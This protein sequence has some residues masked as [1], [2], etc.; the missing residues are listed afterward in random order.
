[1]QQMNDTTNPPLGNDPAARDPQGTLTNNT[2]IPN[3]ETKTETKAE[4]QTLLNSDGKAPPPAP[5]WKE[6]VDD[7][8]K[9]KEENA[10]A[11]AEH[12]K[13]KPAPVKA[14]EYAPIKIEDIKLPEGYEL[15]KDAAAAALPVFHELKIDAAG[16]SKLVALYNDLAAKAQEAPYKAW[17]ELNA[18]W[19][20]DAKA[21][22]ELGP[23]F[24]QVKE[25][26]SR[27]L[28]VALTPEQRSEFSKAM[29]LTGAGNHPAFIRAF[30][31]LAEAFN[32]GKHV[33][34]KGPSEHGQ[35]NRG[36]A[37]PPTAAQA[38]YPNL[39]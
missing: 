12:D 24:P 8:A 15:D 31:K 21:D 14:G 30:Y 20:A 22:A 33:E 7:P 36:H 23:I 37:S 25:S 16:A 5:E 34:G 27:A 3:P 11:K 18:K 13:T 35:N 6:Y 10:A 17:E 38:M 1:M 19:Q 39:K 2:R 29:D 32:E 28:D 4:G 9:S 26:I